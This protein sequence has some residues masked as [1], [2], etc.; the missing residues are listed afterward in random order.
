[1][2]Q[3]RAVRQVS[4]AALESAGARPPQRTRSSRNPQKEAAQP[5]PGEILPSPRAPPTSSSTSRARRLGAIGK[6]WL[7]V[8][9]RASPEPIEAPT[10]LGGQFLASTLLSIFGL[11]NFF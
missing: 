9:G 1:M 7:M 10:F 8:C 3:L 11:C 5:L 2:G 4:D 6:G